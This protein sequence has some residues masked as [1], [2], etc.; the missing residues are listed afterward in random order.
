MTPTGPREPRYGA[1]PDY[2]ILEGLDDAILVVDETGRIIWANAASRRIPGLDENDPEQAEKVREIAGRTLAAPGSGVRTR[3][4]E[5]R[6]GNAEGGE[7]GYRCSVWKVPG[8]RDWIIQIRRSLDL[9]DYEAIVEYTGTATILIEENGV[10]SVA[11]TEFERLSGYARTEIVGMK[12]LIDFIASDDEQRQ[13]TGYHTLR[14]RDPLAAPKNYSFSFIDRSGDIHTVEAA[15][16]LIPGTFR[17]VMSLL[18]VTGRKR[19]EQALRESEERYR[20]LAELAPDVVFSIDTEGNVLYANSIG[21][22]LLGVAP[23]S[24]QGKNLRDIFPHAI[25]K[26]WLEMLRAATD[27]AGELI[28]EETLLPGNGGGAW[29]EAR[30]IPMREEGG[31]VRRFLGISRDITDRKQAE[32]QLRFQAQVLDQVDNAVIALDME[33]RITY[34]NW[35]AERLYGVPS[36]EALGEFTA[37][38]FTYGWL[39]PGDEEEARSVLRDHGFWRGVAIHRKRDGKTIFASTTLSPLRDESGG[40]VGTICSIRDVTEQKEIEC[41]LR[42][43]DMAIASSPSAFAI[44]DLDGRLTYANQAFLSMWGYASDAEVIG[45]GVT[46]FWQDEKKS[47]MAFQT[48]IETGRYASKRIGRKRDGTTFHVTFSGTLVRDN[49][50][51]PLCITASLNDITDLK[52]AEV[53]IQAHNRELSILN[54]IIGVSTSATDLDE[55]PERVLA[56]TLTLLDLHGGGIYLIEPD[57]R[58]ARL[59]CMQNLPEGFPPEP[60]IP[61]IT[62]QPYAEVLVAGKALFLDDHPRLRYS[63]KS[64][65][66][67]CPYAS[68]PVVAHGRVIGA[69][70]VV[71]GEG[72][73]FAGADRSLLTAIGKEIGISIERILLIRQLEMAEQE[74]N[75]YLDVLSHDIRNAEN[76]SGLYTGILIDMLDGE[77]KSYAEKLRSSIRKSI[78]IVRNVSTI[79]RIHHE[80]TVLAPIDLSGVIQSEIEVFSGNRIHYSGTDLA[81]MADLLLPEVFANLIGNAA[82]FGGPEVEITIRVEESDSEVEISVEDTGPGVPDEM[83]ETIFTRFG[84]KKGHKSGQGLGLSITRMLITRYGGT[85]RV[86]D[87]VPGRPECG[88][89]FRF[90]LKKA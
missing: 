70:N 55:A 56:A 13:L 18:D 58:S 5:C 90:T 23:E 26:R 84:K 87:R 34:M 49:D 8:G 7:Q 35:A 17:S 46:E 19:A 60:C 53:E 86:E 81:V 36:G 38:L 44:A 2:R 33:G 41:E 57:K 62:V 65:K 75:F 45:R 30:L 31:A 40:V 28:I 82:K 77:A 78:D 24:L 6:F 43:K 72:R 52:L 74:A 25:V 3:E 42:I 10:I 4:F 68:I 21:A 37:G 39:H 54:Q 76:V 15:I 69:L 88:A 1:Q 12:R 64:D 79:R 59:V 63:G 29:F 20:T 14:R 9:A 89:A 48:I 32:E 85:L 11:N 61:D 50:G 27:S 66:T 71:A 83:K 47:A 22:R 67:P 73:Q 51:T 80:S 16:G